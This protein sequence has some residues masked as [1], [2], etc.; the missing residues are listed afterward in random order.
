MFNKS[1]AEIRE[2]AEA[3]KETGINYV[4]TGHCTKNR[5]YGI[6]KEILGDRLEQLRVGLE[7]KI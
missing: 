2:V 4:C 1:E 7:I 3:I 6:M 5:A